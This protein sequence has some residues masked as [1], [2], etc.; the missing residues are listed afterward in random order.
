VSALGALSLLAVPT[1]GQAVPG[2]L[3]VQGRFRDAPS[4]RSNVIEQL[5]AGT[6]VEI[7]EV[8]PNYWRRVQLADGRTGYIWKDHFTAESLVPVPAAE[9]A[10]PAAAE[11]AAAAVEPPPPAPE[12]AA[13]PVA[14]PAVAAPPP[15]P[16]P[17]ASP[18]EVESLR[19]EVRRLSTAVDELRARVERGNGGSPLTQPITGTPIDGTA[20]AA[21]L[22]MLVGAVLSWI[23]TRLVRRRRDR[24]T[25]IRL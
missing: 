11:P 17:A 25:K 23:L 16:S 21:A 8:T 5:P 14:E 4:A 2:T 9:A 24:R 13:V 6:T 3:K 7:I 12:P 1:V 10:P 19:E 22:F 18:S 15:E 20:G